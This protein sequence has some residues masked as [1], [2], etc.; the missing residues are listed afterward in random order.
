MRLI[1]PSLEPTSNSWRS[2][3]ELINRCVFR[4]NSSVERAF[5][6]VNVDIVFR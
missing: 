2:A 4:N 3:M 5:N 6:F 1:L